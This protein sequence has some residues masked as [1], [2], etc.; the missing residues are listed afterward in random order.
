MYIMLVA[1]AI[2]LLRS[3]FNKYNKIPIMNKYFTIIKQMDKKKYDNHLDY[4]IL[5][6][7]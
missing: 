2:L 1:K 7:N 6:L 4:H 5:F 3:G